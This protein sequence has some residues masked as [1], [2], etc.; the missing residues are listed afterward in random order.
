MIAYDSSFNITSSSFTNN[1]VG[2]FGGVIAT[3]DSSCNITSSTITNS[4]ASCV[5]GVSFVFSSLYNIVGSRSY[6]NKAEMIGGIMLI[7]DSSTHIT[8]GTFDFNSG[9]LNIFNSNLTFSGLTKLENGE[10]PSVNKVGTR[11]EG[12]AITS[13][14]ST[15]I[16][17]GVSSLSNNQARHGGAILATESKIVMYSVTIIANNTATDSMRSGGGI[18]LQRSNLEIKGNCTISGNYA[19]RGGGIHATSSTVAVYQPGTL[20]F[21]S[22]GAEYGGGLYLK[23][24]PKLYIFKASLGDEHLVIFKDNHANYGGAI[25]VADDTNSGA[26]SPYNECFIQSLLSNL[27]DNISHTLNILFSGNTASEQGANLFGGLLDRCIPSPFAE[28]NWKFNGISYLGELSN[29]TALDTISSLP[30]RVCFCK[31]DSE[32]EP[33]CSYQPPIYEV[34][35]GEAF[36]VPLVAVDQVNRS[37]DANITSSLSSIDGG[38]NEG[39]QTQSVGRS[40]S[41]VIFNVFSPHNSETIT[42]FADGPCGSATPSTRHLVIQFTDCTCPVGFQPRDS[43]TRCECHCD[44]ELSPHITNC[45]PIT[46]S[47]HRMKTNSWITHINDTD[48]PGYVIHPNCPLDYCHPPT[49]NV[50]MNLNLPDGA[51]AQCAYDRRG[52]LCG[53]CQAHLSLSLGSSRC[54]PCHSHWPAVFVVILLAAIIAGILLVTALLALNMTVAVG[55]INGFIFYANIVAANSAVFFPSSEPSFPTVF[56]AWLN[57]D[58]GIDVCFFDGLDTYAKTWIQLT[59]PVYIISIVIIVIIVSEYSPQFARL[60]GKRDPVATLATLILLSYAKLLSVTITALSFA[61]LDYPDGSRETVWLHDGN[62]KYLQGKH[63]ALVLVALLIILIGVPYT[64]LL[65]LWQW[66]VR[67]PNWKVFKWT[68]NTKLN[69]FISVH[70]APYNIKYRYWTGL[71]LH[72]RVILYVTASVA[73]SDSDEPQTALL[74]TDIVVGGLLYL[75]GI[76]GFRAYKKSIVDVVETGLY[77]NLLTFALFGLYDFK[78]DIRKQTAVAYTSTIIAF[79]LLV[80][81]IIYHVYLLVSKDRPPEEVEEYLLA[82]LQ[83]A[84]AEVTHTV[85]E[86][87]KPR[88]PSPLPEANNDKIEVKQLICT[89]TP[90]YQ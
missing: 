70:H 15:V 68:R 72:M 57:L 83:P 60:I 22:N 19:M 10:E 23:V 11:E 75:N 50:S 80:G 26:C 12:G 61:V 69:T 79:I 51:D 46:K 42:L 56:V 47:L 16:F 73:V 28:W 38:F 76:T 27:F 37:L 52:V 20:Q 35:K 58:I 3:F 41:N 82:P 4:S 55:L 36:T 43:E 7:I 13:F 33:D 24:D 29:I 63:R 1:S 32:S 2:C 89:A 64:I 81:V 74:V 77:F 49:E 59:F 87:P 62:V 65:F 53:A 67:A 84:K 44:S 30:V 90:V 9:S 14:Q 86:L 54:L 39:Q 40:C 5:G 34:K 6:S 78:T 31:S 8:N 88:D 71:L 85:I 25:Y 48:P 21:I 66:L 18:S 17:T 45:D